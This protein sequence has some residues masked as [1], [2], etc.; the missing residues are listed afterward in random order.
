MSKKSANGSPRSS[1]EPSPPDSR[2]KNIVFYDGVCIFCDHTVHLL[3]GMDSRRRLS[4]ATLQGKLCAALVQRNQR[5]LGSVDSIIFVSAFGTDHERIDIKS[6]AILRI[7]ETLGGAWRLLAPLRLIPRFLLDHL[8]EAFAK[9]RYRWFGK[10]N[11]A[12]C[13]VPGPED[14]GRFFD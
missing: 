4:F 2:D 9:R 11:A 14:A 7:L 10:K 12:Y 3:Y 13:F 8:Y 5:T 1:G 6:T